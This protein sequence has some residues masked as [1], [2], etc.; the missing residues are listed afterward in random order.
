MQLMALMEQQDPERPGLPSGDDWRA[1]CPPAVAALVE[2][3]WAQT[4]DDRPTFDDA[5]A[6]LDAVAADFPAADTGRLAGAAAAVVDDLAARLTAAE[7][8]RAALEQSASR[9][10]REIDEA[11]ERVRTLTTERDVAT[12]DRDAFRG[13]L[14]RS[15]A[16]VA[17]PPTWTAQADDGGDRGDIGWWRAGRQLVEVS[18]LTD[19]GAADWDRVTALLVESLPSATLVRL[20]ARG[21]LV[22]QKDCIRAD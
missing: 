20:E 16:T 7:A 8:E 11:N 13:A 21:H 4:P 14:E 10:A 6:Q 15:E 17:F 1:S 12:R 2:A 5:L 9:D 3:C 19:A 18:K 22:W